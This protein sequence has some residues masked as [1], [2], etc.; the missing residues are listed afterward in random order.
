MDEGKSNRT[1]N[2]LA[3]ETGANF[4][5]NFNTDNR[6]SDFL[7]LAVNDS[8][9]QDV[10]TEINA[11]NTIVMHTSGSIGMDVFK[12][13]IDDYGVFYP[14]QTLTK[15]VSV[16]IGN[17]PICIEGGSDKS[18]D[19]SRTRASSVSKNVFLLNSEKRRILHLAGVLSN[20]FINHLIAR[21]FDY[22]D[23]NDIE[24]ELLF[25]LLE[26]TLKKI[27][28]AS[29][30][31]TQTGPARRKNKEIIDVHKEMLEKEPVLKNLYS[32]ISDSIIAYYS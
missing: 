20:N 9:L 12:N 10:L 5:G 30:R 25:P 31:D 14:F 22:L 26:E 24:K 21:A 16:D 8:C 6:D 2:E 18:L 7:L 11:Q 27:K 17:V 1:G 28:N 29:P 23:N 13:K 4:F 19:M 15:G 3:K 32:L